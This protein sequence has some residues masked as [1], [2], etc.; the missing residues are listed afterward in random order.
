MPKYLLLYRGPE[1]QSRDFEA[2]SPTEMQELFQKWDSWK[3][4]FKDKIIE[5]GDALEHTGRVL[6]DGDI[7]A[8]GPHVEAKEVIGGF[9]ILQTEDYDEA[10]VVARACP[11]RL[12]PGTKVEIRKLARS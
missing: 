12:V 7:M 2:P 10:V 4:T 3:T 5:H 11:I 8:D 1:S 6:G 9:S